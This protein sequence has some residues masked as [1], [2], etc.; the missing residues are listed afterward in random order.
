MKAFVVEKEQLLHNLQIIRAHAG[1]A[2]VWAVLTGNGYGLG[3]VPMAGLLREVGIDHFAV[4]N[5]R[6]AVEL[7]EAGFEDNPILMLRQTQDEAEINAL[8]DLKVILTVGSTEAAV[9]VNAI[10][11][12]RAA[13]ARVHLKV[14]TGM[15]RYGFVP[16]DIAS[17]L[18]VYEYQKSIVVEGVYTHFNCAFCDEKLTKKQYQDFM[19]VVAEIREAGF[20]PGMVHCCNS[21]AFL[22]FPEMHADAV[23]IG[24]ALLGRLSF[25]DNLGLK[26]I[27]HAEATVEELRWLKK[28][29]TVGYGAGWKAKRPTRIAV[30]SIG[31]YH[32]FG[33][34]KGHDLF[35]I[36]DCLREILHNLKWII[37]GRRLC[38]SVNGKSC[39]VLGHVGM[40]NTIVDVTDVDCAI[41][42]RVV[43]QVNPLQVK[44]M[45]ILYR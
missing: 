19:Q 2:V 4:T 24:S 26:R 40:V 31:W 21:A 42:D 25:R 33:N 37:T 3:A 30:L 34:E 28:G 1:D 29:S 39:H 6:E 9:A 13:M 22:K 38:V 16:A 20:D 17:L 8:L 11:A 23:R 18:K 5:V 44:G 15:G 36:R 7:R 32:G 43:L 41:G 10:A 45:K 27:G 14:D 12:E 35:R